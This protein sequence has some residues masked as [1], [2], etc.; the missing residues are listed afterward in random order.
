M[1]TTGAATIFLVLT[2]T[3][4]GADQPASKITAENCTPQPE[5]RL[6]FT[7]L[8]PGAPTK[9]GIKSNPDQQ[10]PGPRDSFRIPRSPE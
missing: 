1:K 10:A 3:V 4:C 9:T 6:A 2:A 5:C 8:A 7:K